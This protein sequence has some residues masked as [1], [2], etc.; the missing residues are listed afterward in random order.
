MKISPMISFQ[1]QYNLYNFK[2]LKIFN[3]FYMIWTLFL[4]DSYYKLFFYL[5]M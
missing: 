4:F 2:I 1:F 5:L 3:F